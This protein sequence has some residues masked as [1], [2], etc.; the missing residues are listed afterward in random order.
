MPTRPGRSVHDPWDWLAI[1]ED[2]RSSLVDVEAVAHAAV[3]RD[4][5]TST[6]PDERRSIRRLCSLVEA[7]H[8]GV[9][10]VISD[11]DAVLAAALRL[12]D[13]MTEVEPDP[14]KT[15]VPA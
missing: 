4:P 11:I 10:S 9:E 15:P 3:E 12:G 7:T 5:P 1:L 2:I 13:E 14:D 8:G 6:D